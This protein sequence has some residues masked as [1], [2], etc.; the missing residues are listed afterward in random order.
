MKTMTLVQRM[1]DYY[2]RQLRFYRDILDAYE[3][4]PS[5]FKESDLG[6][7]LSREKRW[8]A[9]WQV[10][11][12]EFRL[13]NREWEKAADIPDDERA[14]VSGMAERAQEL[15]QRIV[16]KQNAAVEQLRKDMA[17]VQSACKELR[18]GRDMLRKY[19]PT[20]PADK[21]GTYMDRD[22]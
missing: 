14:A 20:D 9:E 8:Q 21:R 10:L 3:E 15:V 17:E 22:A 18:R 7:F 19:R 12:E 2:E 1:T 11:R 13:L 5:D 4:M 6:P 16:A